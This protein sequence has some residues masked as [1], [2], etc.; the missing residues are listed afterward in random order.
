MLASYFFLPSFST[1]SLPFI[2]FS[3]SVIL[4]PKS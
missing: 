4:F 1:S 2:V 3:P